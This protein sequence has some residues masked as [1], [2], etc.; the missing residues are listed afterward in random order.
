MYSQSVV[1]SSPEKVGEGGR[2]GAIRLT[3]SEMTRKQLISAPTALKPRHSP[4]SLKFV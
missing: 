3:C 1:V 2:E 4:S